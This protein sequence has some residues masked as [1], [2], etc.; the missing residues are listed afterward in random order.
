MS[1]VE[2]EMFESEAST[3]QSFFLSANFNL[4]V[5]KVGCAKSK[6]QRRALQKVVYGS[7][8][9]VLYTQRSLYSVTESG[10]RVEVLELSRHP[11]LSDLS[12]DAALL[13]RTRGFLSLSPS[14]ACGPRVL[15]SKPFSLFRTRADFRSNAPK[16]RR[17]TEAIRNR[18]DG[19]FFQGL[20][21]WLSPLSGGCIKPTLVLEEGIIDWNRPRRSRLAPSIPPFHLYSYSRK[22]FVVVVDPFPEDAATRVYFRFVLGYI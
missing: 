12:N 16:Q 21:S 5:M 4:H 20:R 2:I 1:N 22:E 17:F 19:L 13:V 7:W 11:G 3:F 18:L 15:S 14:R 8:W 9:P 10:A 6:L